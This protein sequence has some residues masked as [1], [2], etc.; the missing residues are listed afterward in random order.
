ME[1]AVQRRVN[2]YKYQVK[3]DAGSYVDISGSDELTT[4]Y[5]VTGL[6]EKT[7]YTFSVRA[8]NADGEGAESSV[9][10]TTIDAGPPSLIGT[11]ILVTSGNPDMRK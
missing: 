8:V 5:T 10:T 4:S 7:E 3:Q 2:D 6:S 1:H 9:T 11:P